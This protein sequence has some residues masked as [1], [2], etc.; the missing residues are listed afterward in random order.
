MKLQSRTADVLF[1][2]DLSRVDATFEPA[3]VIACSAAHESYNVNSTS[4]STLGVYKRIAI[5][6]DSEHCASV[7]K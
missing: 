3:R 4:Y 6:V 5:A 1:T 2:H 7:G